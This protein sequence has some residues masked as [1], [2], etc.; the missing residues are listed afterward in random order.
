MNLRYRTAKV[1]TILLTGVTNL[2]AL[3]GVVSLT[4]GQ[5]LRG[6]ALIAVYLGLLMIDT[7]VYIWLQEKMRQKE[8]R[9]AQENGSRTK[10]G[11]Q[12][13]IPQ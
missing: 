9:D 10:T 5:S 12:K 1:L 6:Y 7:W 8:L 2:L 4:S 3:T 13:E 11:S